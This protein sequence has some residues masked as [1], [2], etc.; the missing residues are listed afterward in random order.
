MLP[1]GTENLPSGNDMVKPAAAPVSAQGNRIWRKT[2]KI[3]TIMTEMCDVRFRFFHN[4]I[5]SLAAL[6]GYDCPGSLRELK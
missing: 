1:I 6:Q 4:P 2:R 5:P 3:R